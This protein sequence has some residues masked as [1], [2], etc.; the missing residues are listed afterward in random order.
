MHSLI[1]T[2]DLNRETSEN[3]TGTIKS[4]VPPYLSCAITLKQSNH[5]W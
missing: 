3:M 4:L 5:S 1:V 2:R